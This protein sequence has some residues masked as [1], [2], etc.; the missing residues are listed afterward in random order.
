MPAKCTIEIALVRGVI[1]ASIAFAVR[2]P[3]AGSASTNTG[4]APTHS[5]ACTVATWVNAGTI[6]SSPLPIP[7]SRYA[8]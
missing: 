4:R 5:T 3:V 8:R 6:T 2:L 7:I 1:A